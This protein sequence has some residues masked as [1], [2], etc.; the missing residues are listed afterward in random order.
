MCIRD[1]GNSF[2]SVLGGQGETALR[3]GEGGNGAELAM[4]AGDSVFIPAGERKFLLEG[5]GEL[6]ITHI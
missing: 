2:Y 6:I 4:K 5:D 1:S 3:C